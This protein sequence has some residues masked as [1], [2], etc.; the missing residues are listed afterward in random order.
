M[1]VI[2]AN[3]DLLD[4]D[5]GMGLADLPQLL[6]QKKFAERGLEDPAAVLR[7]PDQVILLV[8]G[9]MGTQP[10]LPAP[11]ISGTWPA[12]PAQPAVG[13]FHPQADARGSQPQAG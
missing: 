9:P 7:T 8:V 5:L 6:R 10:D 3:A 1:E 2:R 13:G 11:V 12:A 4:L